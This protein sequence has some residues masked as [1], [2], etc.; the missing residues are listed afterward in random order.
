MSKQLKEEQNGDTSGYT[1]DIDSE[2]DNATLLNVQ[3]GFGNV[4]ECY[5]SAS[6]HTRLFTTTKYGKLYMLKGLKTDYLYTPFY[7]QALTKEFEIGLQLDHQNI[8]RTIGMEL[9]PGYGTMI[10]MEHIDGDTLQNI[11]SHNALTADMARKAASQIADALDYMHNKQILHRDLKPSNIMITHNGHN[12]KLI[13]FSLSDSDVFTVLKQPAGTSGYMAPELYVHGAESTVASDIYSYGMVL[14]DM[15]SATGDREL[16]RIAARCTR[17]N[18]SLR[19]ADKSGIFAQPATSPLR[20]LLLAMLI[21]A[22]LLL[23]AYI[24]KE[25]VSPA[26]ASADIG[27]A[28]ETDTIYTGNSVL[29]RALWPA[30]ENN[31][32]PVSP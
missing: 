11:I 12:V 26:P 7:R 8:C 10:V 30:L 20:K 29:D 5:V 27:E 18:A 28:D 17:R 3:D 19:P 23:T 9:V 1:G 14:K 22:S 6:G 15:A 16:A 31:A 2:L 13:D 32:A 25:L 4:T 21:L 24:V